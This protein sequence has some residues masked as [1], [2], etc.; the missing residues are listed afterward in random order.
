MLWLL[1]P[2]VTLTAPT[3]NLVQLPFIETYK[4]YVSSVAYNIS[5]SGGESITEFFTK[6]EATDNVAVGLC[7]LSTLKTAN[8]TIHGS[9]QFTRPRNSVMIMVSVVGE[10]RFGSFWRVLSKAT[11]IAVFVTGTAMFASVTL[12]SLPIAVMVLTLDLLAG[13]FGRAIAGWIVSRVSETEPMIHII[14]STRQEAYRAVSEILSL[15]SD[16]GTPFQIEVNGHV[17]INQRR[18][19]KRSPWLVK[20]LGVIA[21]PFDLR[22][23]HN[24]TSLMAETQAPLLGSDINMISMERKT[25]LAG[26]QSRSHGSNGSDLGSSMAGEQYKISKK[27]AETFTSVSLRD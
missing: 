27:P 11:S 24:P 13:I 15:K 16:D 21:E 9:Q 22:R 19:T 5:I 7:Q 4:F 10:R 26:E 23:A 14:S 6:G 3:E 12:L 17:F 8:L 1:T 2:T 18:M 20:I 25:G